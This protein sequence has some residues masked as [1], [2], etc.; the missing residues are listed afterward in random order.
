MR[1]A[2][3]EEVASASLGWMMKKQ[4]KQMHVS[5]SGHK[6]RITAFWGPVNLI[7][8]QTSSVWKESVVSGLCT[9]AI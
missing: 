4:N 1:E 7:R 8:R 5:R 6:L 3:M 9:L 2:F